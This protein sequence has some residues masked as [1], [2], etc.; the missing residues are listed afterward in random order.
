MSSIL[1]FNSENNA[2]EIK[3]DKVVVY[4]PL[5]NKIFR[6]I[7]NRNEDKSLSLKELS[8]IAY[9]ASYKSPGNIKGLSKKELKKD[10]IINLGLPITWDEDDLIYKGIEEVK[11]EYGHGVYGTITT[12]RHAHEYIRR[13]VLL[14]SSA[15][16]QSL[17]ALEVDKES[18][19]LIGDHLKN[20]VKSLVDSF[21]SIKDITSKLDNDIKDLKNI[22]KRVAAEEVKERS[23]RGDT[24]IPKSAQL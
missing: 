16:E 24:Y 14:L 10:A 22:E 4:L 17:E 12:I 6:E 2:V 20:R 8:Y 18:G 9:I 13:S 19:T 3:D 21:E 5:T 23:G 1:K 15:L 11:K 7:Y